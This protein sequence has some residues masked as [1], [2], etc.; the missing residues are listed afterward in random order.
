MPH[1]LQER[2]DEGHATD[3]HFCDEAIRHAQPQ[4]QRQHVEI[5]G[6]IRRVDF[7]A[8][9]IHILP[10]DDAYIAPYDREQEL[11]SGRGE[12]S[13]FL[14]ILDELHYHPGGNNP[15]QKYH[16]EI[17]TVQNIEGTLYAGMDLAAE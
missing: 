8:G 12:A 6:V 14:V 13:R 1:L 9:R 2:A 11:E 7:C 5:T 3:F 10:A 15:K 4:H 16:V 17:N